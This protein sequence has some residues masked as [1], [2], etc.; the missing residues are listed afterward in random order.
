MRIDG[1]DALL[2][3][4][5]ERSRSISFEWGANDC[6]LWVARWVDLVTGTSVCDEWDGQYDSEAGAL[7]LM[8]ER[9]FSEPAA[10]AD[11]VLPKVPL[12][13]AGRGDIVLHPTGALGICDGRT[14][15]FLLP[16]HG[17]TP[18]PTMMCRKAWKV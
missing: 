2:H 13:Y 16:R 10:I 7:T 17:M 14:S 15:Y 9:G 6:C 1:W 5:L 4:Y 8:Q 3:D 12:Q 11:S 18:V